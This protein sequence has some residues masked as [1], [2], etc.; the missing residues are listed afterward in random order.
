[1]AALKIPSLADVDDW[2]DNQII[3]TRTAA[4]GFSLNRIINGPRAL[5]SGNRS[6]ANGLCGDA[7]S[8]V[9][10]RFIDD[11]SVQKTSDGYMIGCILW[12]GAILNHIAN[13]MLASGKAA[14]QT[15]EAVGDHLN[16]KQPVK[17]DPQYSMNELRGLH[18]YDLYYKKRSTVGAWWKERDDG[19]GG[20]ITVALMSDMD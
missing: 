14:K 10:D 7:A 8:Y 19:L 1:M 16:L 9:V 12:K 13:V 6:D 11:L 5:I 20:A 18:V 3:K 4:A 17:G 2:F 15:Y